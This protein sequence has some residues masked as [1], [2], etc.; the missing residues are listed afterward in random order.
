MV[1]LKENPLIIGIFFVMGILGLPISATRVFYGFDLMRIAGVAVF[2]IIL[3]LIMPYIYG[4]IFG[5]IKEILEGKRAGFETLKLEGRKH[6]LPLL[7]AYIL[8][9]V[10]LFGAMFGMGMFSVMMGI[11]ARK[12]LFGGFQPNPMLFFFLW[13]AGVG[14]GSLIMFFFQFFDVGIVINGYGSLNTFKESFRFVWARK[15]SVLGYSILL[16][17][18]MIPMMIPG[19]LL[20]FTRGAAGASFLE[21]L[22]T[23]QAIIYVIGTLFLTTIIGAVMTA[24]RAVYYIQIEREN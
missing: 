19:F 14:L 10:I 20:S 1:L 15:L 11:L 9:F 16:L 21:P 12:G 18:I 3:W 4:G 5:M 23:G 2:T 13:M 8:F 24:Y 17:L 7:V 6:Y 22:P